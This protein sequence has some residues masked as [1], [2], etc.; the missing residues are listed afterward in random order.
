MAI[1]GR[2]TTR[3]RLRRA[4]RQAR[5]IPDLGAPADCAPWVLGDLW[6]AELQQVTAETASLA[7]YLNS[8]LRRIAD[9]ANDKLQAISRDG[10]VGPVRQAAETRVI[11]AARAFAT[12][13]IESTLRQLRNETAPSPTEHPGVHRAPPPTE[14]I[15]KPLIDEP[16]ELNYPAE[17]QTDEQLL[18][19]LLEF[20]A[21][22][23]PRLRWAVGIHPDGS[24]VLVTDLACG[25]IPSGVELPTGARLLEP[26]RRT[27]NAAALLSGATRIESYAPGDRLGLPSDFG[28]T[29]SSNQPRKLPIVDDLGGTLSA[30]IGGRDGL[31]QIVGTLAT[32]GAAGARVVGAELDLLRVHLD[33]AR[34]LLLAQYPDIDTGVLLNCLLLAATAAIVTG[35]EASANYHLAWF[36]ALSSSESGTDD[37]R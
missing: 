11:S 14:A 8:D 15:P 22:Q 33:T 1:F 2:K 6:P 37:P 20:V 12:L 10:L 21:R 17:A 31:P 23:E 16:A 26:G 24:T 25:W 3:R 13:R 30:A 34:Y 28:P 7:G 5:A 29:E 18:R 36:Q 4:A 19:R 35:D 27:G 9:S 32:A